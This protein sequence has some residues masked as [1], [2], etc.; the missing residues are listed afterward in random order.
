MRRTFLI[1][2]RKGYS[3]SGSQFLRIGIWL[4]KRGRSRKR[5]NASYAGVLGSARRR[6]CG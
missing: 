1:V 2:V 5:E 6:V 3:R 4:G